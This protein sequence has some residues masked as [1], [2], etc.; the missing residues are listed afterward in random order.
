MSYKVFDRKEYTLM[1][2]Q[3]ETKKYKKVQEKGLL[4]NRENSD[5]KCFHSEIKKL[6]IY[7][8]DL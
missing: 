2:K 5:V 8:I 1:S 4:F 7:I 6:K 3:N